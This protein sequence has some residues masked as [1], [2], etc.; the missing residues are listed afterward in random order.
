MSERRRSW[1]PWIILLLLLAAVLWADAARR[2]AVVRAE[3]ATDSAQALRVVVDSLKALERRQ[4][5]IY[6][7][8]V[9][10]LRQWRTRWDSVLVP[11]ATDTVTIER[12]VQ[13]ADSTIRACEAVVATCEERVATARERGDSAERMAAHWQEA[14][15]QWKKAARGPFVRP[16]V[17][18]TVTA[19]LDWQ[20]AGEVTVGRG[21]F[22]VLARLDVGQ[23]AETC[24][25]SPNTEAYT[26]STPT[27]ATAR[28]G[29]R[30]GL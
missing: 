17:E 13:V 22:K 20:A 15:A 23:G 25:F 26:C 28:F 29:L 1:L 16:A 7:G 9:D 21:R 19:G 10:T 4:D 5:T 27:E 2:G 14:A 24:A 8:R 11:G 6:A 18:G 12:V 3:A 30:W